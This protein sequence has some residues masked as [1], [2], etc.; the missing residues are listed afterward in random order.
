L[1]FWNLL[2]MLYGDGSGVPGHSVDVWTPPP[3]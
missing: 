3:T 2:V 1:I